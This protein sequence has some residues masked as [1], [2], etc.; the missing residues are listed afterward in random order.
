MERVSGNEREQ[1]R[2]IQNLKNHCAET[3]LQTLTF[4]VWG[5]LL[6]RRIEAILPS[7]TVSLSY[8]VDQQ[9]KVWA[10][11]SQ[12]NTDN[13]PDTLSCNAHPIKS[14]DGTVQGTLTFYCS[15]DVEYPSFFKQIAEACRPYCLLAIEREGYVTQIRKLTDFDALTNVF[16]RSHMDCLI[17]SVLRGDIGCGSSLTI[18]DI[19]R[20]KDVN[21][22]MGHDAGDYVLIEIAARLH[23]RL[24]PNQQLG[25]FG[26]DQFLIVAWDQSIDSAM[27]DAAHILEAI[28]KPMSINGYQFYVSASIGVSHC[29]NIDRK[30]RSELLSM[31]KAA[32]LC[33]K[34]KGGNTYHLFSPAMSQLSQERLA[35]ASELKIA[36]A[37]N[38]LHLQYQPQIHSDSGK[39]YGVEALARWHSNQFGHVPPSS[40]IALAEETG[41]IEALGV[42]VVREA[43]RQMAEW[44]REGLAVPVISVN[45][46]P[47]N[48][49]NPELPTFLAS[50]L[51]EFNLRGQHITIEITESTMLKLTPSML[52]IVQE[53][54]AL[55]IGLSVDDFG[56]GYA[57]LSN[58]I[59]L[60]LSEIKIDRSFIEA[61][62]HEPHQRTLIETVIGIGRKL[63]L[64][65]IAEGVE[66]AVQYHLLAEYRCPIQ[67]GYFFSRPLDPANLSDWLHSHQ[68]CWDKTVAR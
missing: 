47:I 48:F 18:L 14:N 31:A 36:I 15:P 62:S 53:I 52:S 34:E 40:F 39:L 33:G 23:G 30:N 66:T 20:L 17:D 51:H 24:S 25:R 46:S 44:H 45:L 10:A 49:Y 54:R 16:N 59:D 57:S 42:W 26:S 13:K 60:P 61:A 67:Q 22:A 56:T 5:E 11:P 43:C 12:S 50:V 58:L 64:T 6:C 65:V 7:V 4:T 35:K 19:D 3:L 68:Q 27:E 29:T 63:G 2:A 9:E 1:T 41:Q 38:R 55:G 32:L 28:N 8:N 37:E 21:N